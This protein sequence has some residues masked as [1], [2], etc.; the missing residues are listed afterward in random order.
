MNIQDLKKVNQSRMV[1]VR[2][3]VQKQDNFIKLAD[4][5]VKGLDNIDPK[6]FKNVADSVKEL[7]AQLKSLPNALDKLN[8]KDTQEMMDCMRGI[9]EA[10]NSKDF[11]PNID[12]KSPA[13]PQINVAPIVKAIENLKEGK[14]E[15]KET[16]VDLD[17]YRGVVIDDDADTMQY[18][19]FM[20]TKGE[21]YIICNDIDDNKMTY[22]FGKTDFNSAWDSHVNLNYKMLDVAVAEV[23]S[24]VSA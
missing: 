8:A 10:I 24:E 19:G 17:D 1:G 15:D 4:T 22:K 21:W 14:E 16:G 20:N 6:Q 12:V 23:Y 3:V 11:S 5:I 7:S 13:I 9:Q 18:I 2:E